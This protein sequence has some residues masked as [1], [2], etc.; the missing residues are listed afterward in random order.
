MLLRWTNQLYKW[1]SKL[2]IV[3]LY[4]LKSPFGRLQSMLF[5]L[6]LLE[7]N[8]VLFQAFL[9]DDH[10]ALVAAYLELGPRPSPASR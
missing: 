9:Y 4:F 3:L 1:L 6:Q 2:T 10:A 7:S 5:L 8:L